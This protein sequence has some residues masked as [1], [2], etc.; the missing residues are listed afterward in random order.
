MS[1]YTKIETEIKNKTLLVCAL[2]EMKRRG[3]IT[4][5]KSHVKTGDL[6][7]DRS[8]DM[9]SITEEKE[10]NFQVG[11]DKTVATRFTDRLKQI[12]AY[13]TI[14]EN[15]PLDFEVAKETETGG[16]IK[17]ILKGG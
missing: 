12:Y 7:V 10:G 3:E 5:F 11:G 9:L 8:G 4:D 17:L 13:E 6:K 2:E 14:K 1:F 15:L 16:E